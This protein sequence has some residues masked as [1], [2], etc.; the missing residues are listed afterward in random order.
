MLHKFH[1]TVSTW[2]REEDAIFAC[3]KD[4]KQGSN[5]STIS[6]SEDRRLHEFDLDGIGLS[7]CSISNSI[8][9][10]L[11]KCRCSFGIDMEQGRWDRA[12]LTPDL[13]SCRSIVTAVLWIRL[14]S[15]EQGAYELCRYAKPNYVKQESFLFKAST[16]WL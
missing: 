1:P 9:C 5:K 12:E 4:S 11:P 10:S 14:D 15:L 6:S 13:G 8:W 7:V 3:A 16:G 2:N